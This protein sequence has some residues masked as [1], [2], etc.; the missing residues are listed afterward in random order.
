MNNELVTEMLQEVRD[1]GELKGL[2]RLGI[3]EAGMRKSITRFTKSA[4]VRIVYIDLWVILASF[5]CT[6]IFARWLERPMR[7]F[8]DKI[9]DILSKHSEAV[10]TET[11]RKGEITLEQVAG[12]LEIA[13]KEMVNSQKDRLE[14]V[15]TLSHEFRSP[16]QAI[17]GYAEYLRSGFAGP[18]NPEMDNVL[19]IIE[20]G[21]MRFEQFIN[22]ILDLMHIE[23][24][25]IPLNVSSKDVRPIIGEVSKLLQI[26]AQK[27]NVHIVTEIAR[28]LRL[29]LC[30]PDK[31]H[32]ILL[33]LISNSLKFTPAGGTI[34]IEVKNKYDFIEFSVSDT[35]VGIPGEAI[36]QVFNKFY[37]VPGQ[38]PKYGPTKGL[39]IGLSI[40]RALVEAQKGKIWIESEQ[41]QGTTVYFTL[42]AVIKK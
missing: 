1:G 6:F 11:D 36:D 32:R 24:G 38:Y 31:V 40:C 21:S 5:L 2:V 9:R 35:G 23:T 19:G 27:Q 41:R 3:R 16:L 20:E 42:P 18:V 30:D 37:Q 22:G 26:Q 25:K 12:K 8:Q 15:S 13:M 33:N 7:K 29:V 17:R 39:G 4:L 10:I 34:K 28:G 14:F